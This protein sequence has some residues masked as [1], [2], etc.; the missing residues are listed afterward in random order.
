MFAT[1]VFARYRGRTELDMWTPLYWQYRDPD[2][3]LDRKFLF[4]FFY[5]NTSPRSDDIAVFPFFARFQK[6]GLSETTCVTPLFRHTTDVTG[7]ETDLFPLFFVGRQNRSS[8]LDRRA[9]PLGLRLAALAH[10]GRAARV[11]P[12]RRRELGLAAR[13]QHLL[14]REKVAG[15]TDW[16][17]HFFPVFSYG[18]S[19]TGHWWNVL[20][21]PRGLHARRDEGED[22]DLHPDR[23]QRLR[24]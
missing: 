17:F 10:D 21:R 12:H 16:E 11:L 22:A 23:P 24:P 13:A 4:P 2:I 18:Q 5:R 1:C 8:H 6:P 3:G 14:P 20:L 15:G 19:P 9:V 7:W